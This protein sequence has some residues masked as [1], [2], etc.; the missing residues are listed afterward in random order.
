MPP[1]PD[2]L[3]TTNWRFKLSLSFCVSMRASKS[4]A[5]PGA[6]ATMTRTGLDGYSAA[7][8]AEEMSGSANTARIASAGNGYFIDCLF[9]LRD[10]TRH[11]RRCKI[12]LLSAAAAEQ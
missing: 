7:L 1:P 3:S 4:L 10:R 8:C 9:R 6:A 12:Y 2:R 11:D 5:P